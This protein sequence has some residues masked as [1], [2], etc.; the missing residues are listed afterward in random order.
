MQG[1]ATNRKSR[2]ES[3]IL[4]TRFQS[5]RPRG[6]VHGSRWGWGRA[7]GAQVRMRGLPFVRLPAIH[8]R[9][10]P[11]NSSRSPALRICSLPNTGRWGSV[12]VLAV[13]VRHLRRVSS[14]WQ[15]C[16][17]CD[18]KEGFLAS[19]RPHRG[20]LFLR[21]SSHRGCD[22]RKC[23]EVLSRRRPI[24]CNL[25]FFAIEAAFAATAALARRVRELAA[26]R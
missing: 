16:S 18:K 17:D 26:A 24:C 8:S 12:R 13:Y 23:S 19:K 11:A 5:S 10:R 3:P 9:L 21:A 20:G 14:E 6:P 7:P 2:A 15:I 25:R 22:L 4:P 1:T